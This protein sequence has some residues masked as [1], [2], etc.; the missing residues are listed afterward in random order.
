MAVD[1]RAERKRLFTDFLD[2]SDESVDGK[3]Y[4]EHVEAMIQEDGSRLLVDLADLRAF[5]EDLQRKLRKNPVEY[6]DAFEDALTE[7]VHSIDAK[8][9]KEGD[10]VHVGFEGQFGAHRVSPRELLSEYLSSMVQV[11]G[12]V[13]KCSLVRPKVVKSVHY[14]DVTKQFTSREYRDITSNSGAPTGS[15]YPTRDNDGNL[16]TTEYGL[17][18]YAD[19]QTLAIQEM[20]ERAPPGQLPRSVDVIIENDLVDTCKP[21]DRVQI[22][23]IYKAIPTR[24]Q[25]NHGGTFRTVLVANGVKTMTRDQS[26]LELLGDD[27]KEIKSI[28]KRKD[29]FDLLADSLAPS[30]FGHQSIKKA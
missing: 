13:T 16:L 19:H 21:G 29:L 26:G 27:L 7:V 2:N 6:M 5:D 9:I 23:G 25:G 3:G 12:I 28:A 30:I 4:R 10:R 18:V 14:A 22:T 15:S 24:S 17:S 1:I 8:Y 11:E 20:P